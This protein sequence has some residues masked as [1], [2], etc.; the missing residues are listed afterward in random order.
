[1]AEEEIGVGAALAVKMGQPLR[2]KITEEH[3][4]GSTMLMNP[5]RMAVFLAAAETPGIPMR[6]MAEAAGL[7]FAA[8]RWNVSRLLEAGL[9][10]RTESRGLYPPVL[11]TPEEAEMLAVLSS[12]VRALLLLSIAENPGEALGTLSREAGGSPQKTL[13]HLDRMEERGV[14]SRVGGREGYTVSPAFKEMASR[15]LE[16]EAETAESVKKLFKEENLSPARTKRQNHRLHV[17]VTLSTGRR[18]ISLW[19][20]PPIVV[21]TRKLLAEVA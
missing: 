1:M 18:R 17:E 11:F 2:P 21:R 13:Y 15:L 8:V 5:N 3:T 14:V 10:S 6:R 12:P 20:V 19:L 7:P 4:S 16:R 9:L